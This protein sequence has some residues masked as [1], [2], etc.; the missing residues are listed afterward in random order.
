MQTCSTPTSGEEGTSPNM[1]IDTVEM[2]IDNGLTLGSTEWR[3]T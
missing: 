2:A 3:H 1:W